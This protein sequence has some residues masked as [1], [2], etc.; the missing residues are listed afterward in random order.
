MCS[1]SGGSI[2]THAPAGGA[3]DLRPVFFR[4]A[5]YFYSR[6][7]GR[8][9]AVKWGSL[10][11]A[12]P[13]LLTPLR[14]GRRDPQ[15]TPAARG[16]NFY[17]RPCG[18]GDLKIARFVRSC[19]SISTHA[20]AGGATVWHE[21]VQPA[22]QNFYSRPCGRGDFIPRRKT[23]AAAKFLLTP[24][25]EGRPISAPRTPTLSLNFY[26]RPCGRGDMYNKPYHIL[27]YYFYSRPCG[28]GDI[29]SRS[30]SGIFSIFLLTPLREGRPLEFKRSVFVVNISTHAPAGGATA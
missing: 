3:T 24:L 9:D 21:V 22:E 6:P 13:F 7:C 16:C 26:S 18:R 10:P 11:G 27:L 1:Y 20:P 8:G 14:E 12:L 17:S 2:S 28:R 30:F 15:R 25:R 4:R 19:V 5:K 23:G 29:S